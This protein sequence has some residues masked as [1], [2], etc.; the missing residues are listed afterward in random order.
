MKMTMIKSGLKGLI[1]HDLHMFDVKFNKND[2]KLML[3]VAAARHNFKWVKK[4]DLAILEL[5]L[6]WIVGGGVALYGSF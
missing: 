6:S 1:D 2:L 3:W 5:M 4:N